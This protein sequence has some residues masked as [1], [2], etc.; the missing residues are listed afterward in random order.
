MSYREG[1][2]HIKQ[3]TTP[4]LPTHPLAEFCVQFWPL[5]HDQDHLV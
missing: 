4:P 1:Q 3:T 5:F 2:I